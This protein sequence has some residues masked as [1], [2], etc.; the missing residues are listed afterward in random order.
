MHC[1]YSASVAHFSYPLQRMLGWNPQMGFHLAAW[2]IE[3]CHNNLLPPWPVSAR[4]V[5][6][7]ALNS[8]LIN[9]GRWHFEW[10]PAH[11]FTFPHNTDRWYVITYK[12]GDCSYN[13]LGS[14]SQVAP[15]MILFRLLSIKCVN[16]SNVFLIQPLILSMTS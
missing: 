6:F 4:E 10:N 7:L 8:F 9:F 14:Y 13:N 3:S 12:L 15:I 2:N 11:Y 16:I 5:G 1:K